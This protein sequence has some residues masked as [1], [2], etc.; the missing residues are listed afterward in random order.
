MKR[1]SLIMG[2][3][4]TLLLWTHASASGAFVVSYSGGTVPNGSTGFVDVRI[5]SDALDS[6]PDILDLFSAHFLITPVGGAVAGG[7]QFVNPQNDAQLGIGGVGGYVFD[8]D[9]LGQT[10]GGP[11]G[12]VST[13]SNTN[14][15]Y[16]GGDGT[17][18]GGGFS[19]DNTTGSNLLFRLELDAALANLGDQY[20]IKLIND[21][22]T[23]FLGPAPDFNELTLVDSSFDPFTV[24]ITGAAAVPEPSSA[25]ML[26]LGMGG[27]VWNQRRR[28]PCTRSAGQ[29]G[30]EQK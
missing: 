25:V 28:R 11:L 17:V 1:I 2:W 7:L 8:G 20:T 16:I 30:D 27:V 26:L 22:S 6:S 15:N 29:Q 10:F 12:L 21:P 3:T 24:T 19:L 4:L 13:A 9:S 23:S 18:S 14:D 5:S